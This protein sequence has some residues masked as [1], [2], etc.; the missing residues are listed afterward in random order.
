LTACFSLCY[1][2]KRL[3]EEVNPL[4]KTT[5]PAYE[6]YAPYFLFLLAFFLRLWNVLSTGE[7]FYANFL[8]DASTFKIWATRLAAGESY[9]EPVF[10]MGPLYPYFLAG[11]LGLGFSFSSVLVV[12]A[13]LGALTVVLVY[14][15]AKRIAGS[16]PA[17]LSG[18]LAAFYGP[19]IFYDGLLLSESLQVFLLAASLFFLTAD[20]KKHETLAVFAAGLLTGT[21]S[22][23]RG[24]TVFFPL[25]LGAFWI[26]RSKRQRKQNS[27]RD[28]TKTLVLLSGLLLGVLPATLHNISKGDTVLIS[29]NLGINFF[30]GN[31]PGT[32]GTY[33][34]PPGLDLSL[35]FTGRKIA[36]KLTGRRLTSSEVSSFWMGEAMKNMRDDPAAFLGGLARKVWILL[37]Q[38][39]IPQA[40]SLTIQHLFSPVFR[41]PLPGFGTALLLG[42]LWIFFGGRDENTWIVL[43]LLLSNALG[44]TL[45]FVVERYRLPSE[46]ALLV[47]SGCGG[48]ILVDRL[49]TGEMRRI[50][51]L[52]ALAAAVLLILL[53]P[54]PVSKAAKDASALDNVGIASFYR[55]DQNGAMKWFQRAL[56]VSPSPSIYNNIGACF[57]GK[58]A[59]D[60]A[61]VYFHRALALDE[62]EHNAL[63]NLGRVSLKEGGLDSARYYFEKARG[64]A[65]YGLVAEEALKELERIEKKRR[66]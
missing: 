22:L 12:Q 7:D 50:L 33:E 31:R 64:Q 9:G 37:W 42:L 1:P 63:M 21:A 20:G 32:D 24:T 4:A 15:V 61:K 8:S 34:E 26:V 44:M 27:A 52:L 36:E 16:L 45:F 62:A 66:K 39:P 2:H 5:S 40:E 25:M 46:L 30:V 18:L 38:F 47:C 35:D 55:G 29:S 11:C 59:V 48:K 65:P 28:L 19:F 17:L 54:R 60:S 14:T 41:L 13:V 56:E 10:P 51:P 6:R 57:Y 53:L 49:K 23:G 43:L 58:G 3:K